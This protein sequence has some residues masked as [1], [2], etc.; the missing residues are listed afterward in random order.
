MKSDFYPGTCF[1]S[2]SFPRQIPFHRAKRDVLHPTLVDIGFHSA[3]QTFKVQYFEI[4]FDKQGQRFG[5]DVFLRFHFRWHNSLLRLKKEIH[6]HGRVAFGILIH[7]C[8]K[9]RFHLLQYIVL[10][11]CPLKLSEGIRAQQHSV[12]IGFC[13]VSQQAESMVCALFDASI[14]LNFC[15]SDASY[16]LFVRLIH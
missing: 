16:S 1:S 14:L 13:H 3:S 9:C 6:L 7:R 10:G 4:F 2:S 12:G 8:V 11:K 5:L 15:I